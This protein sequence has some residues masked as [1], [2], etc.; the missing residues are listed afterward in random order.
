MPV[1]FLSN[2]RQSGLP[3]IFTAKVFILILL[4]LTHTS[5]LAFLGTVCFLWQFHSCLSYIHG[6]IRVLEF[7]GH[8]Y[9]H[10][11]PLMWNMAHTMVDVLLSD[12]INR[13]V[14]HKTTI[15]CQNIASFSFFMK[16]Q[17]PLWSPTNSEKRISGTLTQSLHMLWF[18]VCLVALVCV[19]GWKFYLLSYSGE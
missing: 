14:C 4:W 10:R 2:P 16:L 13:P 9:F 17:D 19:I 12:Y 6:L 7:N 15:S 1:P 18:S 5:P 8:C 11:L 3:Q